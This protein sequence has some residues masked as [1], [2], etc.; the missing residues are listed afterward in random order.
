MNTPK[1]PHMLASIF[2]LSENSQCILFISKKLTFQG[3]WSKNS[4]LPFMNCLHFREL[5]EI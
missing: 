2:A 3:H 4:Y 1:L 5:V